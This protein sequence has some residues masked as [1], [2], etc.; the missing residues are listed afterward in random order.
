MTTETESQPESKQSGM[1]DAG[2]N[3]DRSSP[4]KPKRRTPLVIFLI[5][6]LLIAIG[7]VIYW[8]HARQFETTDDA[9]IEAHLSPI[10][11]RIDG[12]I[13]KVYVENNQPVK[14]GDPLV[15]LDPRNFKVALDQTLAE[16]AQAR[17]VVMSET[18]N[19]SITQVENTT[20]IATAEAGVAEA[21][22]ALAGAER[23]RETAAAKLLESKAMNQRA[24][25]DLERYKILIAKQEVSQ[26]EYDQYA[27]AAK[28]QAATVEAGQ[29]AV[30]SAERTVDQRRAQLKQAR[31]KLTQYEKNSPKQ[32]FIRHAIVRS[33]KA[34]VESIE[35]QLEQARLNLSYTKIAAPVSGIVIKRS[36]E[37]GSHISAGQQLV[38]IVELGDLWV[39]ANYKETQLRHI[40]RGQPATIH[41]D[42]LDRDFRG[43]VQAIG[44]AT[45]SIMSVL[46]PENATGNYVKVVQR[47]PVRIRLDPNQDGMERLRPGMSVEPSIRISD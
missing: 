18:P 38:T 41:V 28:S 44:G 2:K 9:Q 4:S 46:P 20:N 21:E 7:A 11:S 12:T 3:G 33:H 10:S 24:Q 35:A 8:L 43:S 25:A 27:A 36:A 15:D 32:L 34:N 14:I 17:E 23:D 31:N 5:V 42:A 39:T 40:R 16:L 26:A 13:I 22:A 1:D 47:I 37:I 30:Q 45:G 29:A 19:V 6:V